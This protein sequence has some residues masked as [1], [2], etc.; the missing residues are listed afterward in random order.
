[1]G[2]GHYSPNSIPEAL[3]ALTS[4]W[5]LFGLGADLLAGFPGETEKEHEETLRL[6]AKLPLSYAHVFPYSRR[7][8]TAAASMPE[9]IAPEEKK[10][11]AAELRALVAEK[12]RSF[13]QT[14]LGVASVHVAP[15][16][17]ADPAL[18]NRKTKTPELGTRCTGVNEYYVDC[19][20]DGPPPQSR[21]LVEARPLRLEKD[22][23]LVQPLTSGKDDS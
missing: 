3:G 1:M 8:G 19:L 23:L 21:D 20:I 14:L 16:H 18:Q 7:P 2:R 5:P 9:Q 22:L 12:R 6:C 17:V 13:L 15:E 11:R 4:A 10:R